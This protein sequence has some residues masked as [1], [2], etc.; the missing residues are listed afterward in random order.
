VPYYSEVEQ[1]FGSYFRVFVFTAHC[2]HVIIGT[3]ET[4]DRGVDLI[5]ACVH[6]LLDL[7]NAQRRLIAKNKRERKFTG[8][9]VVPRATYTELVRMVES[10]ID[11]VNATMCVNEP[12]KSVVRRSWELTGWVPGARLTTDLKAIVEKG[13]LREKYTKGTA[14][15]L[16]LQVRDGIKRAQKAKNAEIRRKKKAEKDALV[17]ARK[18]KKSGRKKAKKSSGPAKSSSSSTSSSSSSSCSSA[19]VPETAPSSAV[20][21][22]ATTPA[23][24]S[25]GGAMA[26]SSSAQVAGRLDRSSA[27]ASSS[28]SRAIGSSAS[29]AAGSSCV[30]SI[31]VTLAL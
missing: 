26:A 16:L 2:H 17:P 4:F 24:S 9:G 8:T 27:A 10:A 12:D 6:F 14:P 7:K 3:C 11:K 1:R 13:D 19:F 25:G 23:V 5:L 20:S 31:C 21:S 29:G 22:S 18:R 30:F 15:G 28:G